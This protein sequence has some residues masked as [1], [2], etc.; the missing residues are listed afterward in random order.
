MRLDR[1]LD[2]W[3][4]RGLLTEEQA[5]A[6]RAFEEARAGGPLGW[7]VWG[8]AAAGGVTVVVGVVAIVAANWKDVPEGA[9]LAAVG[10]LLLAS[11]AGAWRTSG[12]RNTWPRDLCLLLHALLPLAMIGL[13]AQVYHLSGPPW[14]TFALCGALALPGVVLGARSL[15]TDVVLAYVVLAAGFAVGEV[16]WLRRVFY[17]APFGWG[18]LSATGGLVLLA[19]GRTA[20]GRGAAAPAAALRRWG[21][22]LLA[23]PLVATAVEW[24]WGRATGAW[25]VGPVAILLAVG[26]PVAWRL[27]SPDRNRPALAAAALGGALLAATA[28][29]PGRLDRDAGIWLGFL[30]FCA[31]GVALAMAAA[32]AG[33][34][35]WVTAAT[36]AIA[37]RV[38]VLYLVLARDL[39]TTGIGL[40]G[41][42]LVICAVAWG[43]WRLNRVLRLP[44]GAAAPGGTP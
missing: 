36:L 30:L 42:G 26:V 35:R 43:W 12:L 39:M 29:L 17:E 13:I 33:R 44:V 2:L 4:N 27:A 10:T 14:R 9:K 25:D 8:L 21:V 19:L 20:A 37:A 16:G 11:L 7:V 28:L 38:V 32:R 15:L 6:I 41:S 24:R 40:V 5:A 3:R 31:F 22:A 23:V 1:K 18:L 34:R